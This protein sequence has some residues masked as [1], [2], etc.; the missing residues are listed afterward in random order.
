MRSKSTMTNFPGRAAV[1]CGA[2]GACL[3]IGLFAGPQAAPKPATKAKA[4]PSATAAPSAGGKLFDTPQQA[5]DALVDAAEKFDVAALTEI[6]GPAGN[7]IVFSG[8]MAQDRK[9][10]TD[11]AAQARKKKSVSVD[12]KAGARAFLLVGEE[13]WPFPVPLVQRGGKWYF[14]AKAGQ[15]ELLYR[16]IGANELDAIEVRHDVADDQS[17][18]RSGNATDEVIN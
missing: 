16:R 5:A 2:V 10:A 17:Q 13:D 6:F 15:Q 14:D 18:D 4:T 12:P 3:T 7:D 11:F 8:E 9:H 1:V